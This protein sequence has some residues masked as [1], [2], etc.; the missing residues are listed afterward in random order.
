MISKVVRDK[1]EIERRAKERL[2]FMA[3][4]SHEL[5]TPLNGVMGS[6]Q[7]LK[8]LVKD[9]DVVELV[10]VLSAS[11]QVLYGVIGNILD[12][13]KGDI[14]GIVIEKEPIHVETFLITIRDVWFQLADE[15]GILLDL[16]V[17]NEEVHKLV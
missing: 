2:M 6:I 10:H 8:E 13:A 4:V 7:L 16:I 5:R 11:T 15:K 9:V 12:F 3:S 17:L 1:E 14:K